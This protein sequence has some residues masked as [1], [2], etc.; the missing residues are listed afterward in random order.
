VAEQADKV[1]Y[2]VA[3]YE[4]FRLRAESPALTGNQRS[5]FPDSYRSGRSDDILDDITSK[6]AALGQRGSRILDIGCGCGELALRLIERT[7]GLGQ[8]L[9]LVDSPEM[10][11]QLPS[12]PH[13]RKV[14]GPFP[15]CLDRAD[16]ALG[17]FDAILVY[18]VAQYV[19]AEGNFFGFVDAALSLLGDEG[20]LLIGDLP[21]AA[22]RARFLASPSGARHHEAHYAGSPRPDVVFNAPQPNQ[23]DDAVILG[24]VARARAAGFQG[25]VVPQAPGLPMA[26]R[27]EDVLIR[28]P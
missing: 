16:D 3:G 4:A 13:V 23:L 28:R 9:T 7:G 24:L 14:V 11:N 10:L 1:G 18:S 25:F 21:N 12:P 5:G 26:N 15:Q 20:A 19:F 17:G 8:A 6:L 27:R 2:D 22:M